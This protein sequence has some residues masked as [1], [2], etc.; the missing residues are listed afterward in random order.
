MHMKVYL[1]LG[2]LF[3]CA[4]ADVTIA[5]IMDIQSTPLVEGKGEV[6]HIRPTALLNPIYG[7]L[8]KYLGLM[9]NQRLCAP[10]MHTAYRVKM[11]D[12]R[13]SG[14]STHCTRYATLDRPYIIAAD[15]ALNKAHQR[16]KYRIRYCKTLIQMFPSEDG[17]NLSIESSR[18]NQ[19]TNILRC[20]QV[21][22]QANYVLVMLLLLCEGVDLI[23]DSTPL[24]INFY[25]DPSRKHTVLNVS[26]EG[27]RYE[28]LLKEFNEIFEFFRTYTGV[29]ALPSTKEQF[30]T[31]EFLYSPHM[32]I[33]S[34]I[35]EYIKEKSEMMEFIR[36]AYRLLKCLKAT[37]TNTDDVFNRWFMPECEAYKTL[38]HF[39]PLLEA[40]CD[41]EDL[42]MFPQMD[43]SRLQENSKM[44]AYNRETDLFDK[45][46]RP[47]GAVEKI[48]LGLV[49]CFA[50][51]PLEKKYNLK[52][53][54]AQRFNTSDTKDLRDFFRLMEDMA[55]TSNSR[56]CHRVWSKVV[57]GLPCKEIAYCEEG[58]TMLK[59]GI[60]N[61]AY[62]LAHIT[63]CPR[64]EKDKIRSLMARVRRTEQG[65][66]SCELLEEVQR[67]ITDLFTLLSVNKRLTVSIRNACLS[68]AADDAAPETGWRDV[69]GEITVKYQFKGSSVVAGVAIGVTARASYINLL[70]ASLSDKVLEECRA[71]E[72]K[73]RLC[74]RQT[75]FL[76]CIL[77]HYIERVGFKYTREINIAGKKS[78]I[79]KKVLEV[80]RSSP[81][82]IVKLCL[83]EWISSPFM[84][85]IMIQY[86]S[87]YMVGEG[88]DAGPTHSIVRFISNLLGSFPF[89]DYAAQQ[90]VSH[91][92]QAT[93][94]VKT[95]YPNV[96]IA[97]SA[98]N[99][100]FRNFALMFRHK[101]L[102]SKEPSH[103]AALFMN[104][105]RIYSAE[106]N[107][108]LVLCPA[109]K[110]SYVLKSAFDCLFADGTA[111]NSQEISKILLEDRKAS[112]QDILEMEKNLVIAWF[113]CSVGEKAPRDSLLTELYTLV[114]EDGRY[115]RTE[116][117]QAGSACNLPCAEYILKRIIQIEPILLRYGTRTKFACVCDI[118]NR[119]IKNS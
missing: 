49:L 111:K 45:K 17:A 118:F 73:N 102:V 8:C 39:R 99:T 15:C 79:G 41:M 115:I 86:L 23:I 19:L 91:I 117:E 44:H 83:M 42:M 98:H 85:R 65:A 75:G 14:G 101:R 48:T 72:K 55:K 1:L 50:H 31:G 4:R 7:L 12:L 96:Q 82:N 16:T 40:C 119:E 94:R 57:G 58:R 66:L 36:S 116:D 95:L 103:L 33:Q 26:V 30:L 60:L 89:N 69:Y 5:D 68:K 37:Q 93:G 52:S 90:A 63:N 34:Y 51:D 109:L 80:V 24:E 88:I 28:Y 18:R 110:C 32:L 62:V 56:F 46:H 21:R 6:M 54:L 70:P 9:H 22:K 107:E 114:Q 97:D 87:E 67:C 20:P 2:G 43:L 10:E 100:L 47:V 59:A 29:V 38:E 13:T 92:L 53:M 84:R 112:L 106:T 11:H 104:H 108:S 76:N 74:S 77:M 78:E 3:A 27:R 64:T 113:A 25:S 71:F 61:I 81:Q 105:L 35:A